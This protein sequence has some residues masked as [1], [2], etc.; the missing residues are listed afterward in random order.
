M[1]DG[2]QID[3]EHRR[4]LDEIVRDTAETAA[5]TGR[6]ELAAPVLRA[7]ARVS[8]QC[9]VSPRQWLSAYENRPLAIGWGQTIS[10]PFVV[11]VMTEL[12]D[13]RPGDRVLEVGTGCGY[14]TAV[15]AEIA[16]RV[17]SIEVVPQLA[18]A[19][20][21]RLRS[22]GYDNV[23]VRAGDGFR[24]WPEE[25]PFDAIIVTAAPPDFPPALDD[26]LAPLG[27]LVIPVGPRNE[28][29]MLWRCE[30]QADGAIRRERKLPVAFVP[31]VEGR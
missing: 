28:A 10:Q 22:L 18:E 5:W 12:L 30:K 3:A 11:A 24:G 17:F 23:K 26:Q 7:M 29:Q 21:K 6:P 9:F 8:R 25:A 2:V 14:Q 31:M 15:L 16:A 1:T 19:A 13:L 20:R 27:R 4:L